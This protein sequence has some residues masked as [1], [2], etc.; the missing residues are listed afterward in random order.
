MANK[1]ENQKI[2]KLMWE[3][4]NPNDRIYKNITENGWEKIIKKKI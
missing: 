4:Q 3:I 1:K 2:V